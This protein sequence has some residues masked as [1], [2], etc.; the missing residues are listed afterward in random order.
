MVGRYYSASILSDEI[1][2]SWLKFCFND[3]F[4]KTFGEEQILPIVPRPVLEC[5]LI[6]FFFEFIEKI[7]YRIYRKIA[8]DKFDKRIR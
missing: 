8:V 4:V 3:K 2:T 5:V 1:Y 7:I 6:D